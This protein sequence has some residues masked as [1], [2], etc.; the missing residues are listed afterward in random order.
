MT[1]TICWVTTKPAAKE[2]REAG[3][4]G[5]AKARCEAGRKKAEAKAEGADQ[6]RATGSQARCEAG[7][8]P[9]PSWRKAKKAAEAARSGEINSAVIRRCWRNQKATTYADFAEKNDSTS[10]SIRRASPT[11]RRRPAGTG[12]TAQII[13]IPPDHLIGRQRPR[14]PESPGLF[15]DETLSAMSTRRDLPS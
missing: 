10:G 12:T 14:R 8:R 6:D 3:E 5:Q 9:K 4:R 7:E 15:V 1:S 2:A 11:A 13:T